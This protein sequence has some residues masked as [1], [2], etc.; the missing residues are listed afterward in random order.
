MRR[1]NALLTGH[2]RYPLEIEFFDDPEWKVWLDLRVAYERS[3]GTPAPR[4]D[5][6]AQ[7]TPQGGI[8]SGLRKWF[9][10]GAGR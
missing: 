3:G 5:P 1:F 9:G 4:P 7:R 8:V 2:E 10:R 6:P